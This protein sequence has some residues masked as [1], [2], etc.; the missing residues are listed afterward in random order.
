MG[1]GGLDWIEQ[2]PAEL[3]GQRRLL[4]GLLALCAANTSIRWLVI[5]CSLARGAGDRRSDLDLG[6]GISDEEFDA[7]VPG[8][9]RAVDSLGDLVES[10]HHQLPSVTTAH[11]RIFAQLADRCQVDLVVFPASAPVG[12]VP[13]I[14]VLYDPDGLLVI[15]DESGPVRP[16][17]APGPAAARERPAQSG[18]P[19]V[20][21]HCPRGSPGGQ[22]VRCRSARPAARGGSWR[23]PG[24][25]R[26]PWPA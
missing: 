2:L 16:G 9:R 8:V 1:L 14:V 24:T 10:Y 15:S 20:P 22:L 3:A 6:M 26:W 5:G 11:E 25:A 7:A 4:R 21:R 12:S 19:A 17:K 18:T 23:R 13:H